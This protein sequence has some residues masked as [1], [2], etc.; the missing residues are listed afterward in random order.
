MKESVMNASTSKYRKGK[1][2]VKMLEYVGI[3]F[4]FSL[5]VMPQYT[6]IPTPLFDLTI[7]R[8]SLIFFF[9]I[10]SSET[11]NM[12]ELLQL[13]FHSKVSKTLLP[14][15][16][17]LIYTM[18]FRVDMNAFL[19]PFFEILQFFLCI[20]LIRDVL[21]LER[22]VK[23]VVA[24][25][26]T[27]TILGILEYLMGTTPFSY[28]KTINGIY[29][30]RFVRSGHYRIMSSATHSLGY[31]LVLIATMPFACFDTEKGEVS[32]ARHWPLIVLVAVNVFLT[33]SRSTLVCLIIEIFIMFCLL[34][35]EKMKKFL[36]IFMVI[37]CFLILFLV[38][39]QKTSMAQYILLQLTSLVDQLFGTTYSVKYG[40]D[41]SAL[42]SSSNY[43]EQ[44]KYIYQLDWLNPLLGLG[45]KRSFSSEINGSFIKSIDDFYVAEYVRYA[46]PGLFS[47]VFFLGYHVIKMAIG[48]FRYKSGLCKVI[49][50]GMISYMLNL[51][52]VDSLQTFKY[53]YLL[54]AVYYAWETNELPAVIEEKA[55][56]EEDDPKNHPSRYIKRR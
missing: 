32:M 38:V 54:I 47:F 24:Y 36:L 45:R 46:Y 56:K 26:Y 11:K 44:L 53:M 30:G 14:Y 7:L 41:L 40:A 48:V 8:I 2:E 39:F 1:R 16:L 18:V 42:G 31:G 5:F 9:L 6:G 12:K 34:G 21:G 10:I 29:T 35:K 52:W 25:L 22:T 17:V 51:H 55:L 49:L 15:F 23:I 4:L 19:N 13:M 20:V 27:L 3:F 43:R 50:V 37:A 33:G 28:L